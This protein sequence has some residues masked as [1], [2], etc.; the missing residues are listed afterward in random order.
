MGLKASRE[1]HGKSV[2]GLRAENLEA[3]TEPDIARIL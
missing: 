2:G 3:F 1:R